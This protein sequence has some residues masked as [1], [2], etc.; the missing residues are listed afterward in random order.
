L[1]FLFNTGARVS[2]AV[3]LQACDLRLAPPA[4]VLL[5]GKG[6]KERVCPL[7]PET[8]RALREYLEAQEIG[9]GETRTVFHNHRGYP[10]TRFGVRWILQKHVRQAAR[11]VPSLKSKRLHPH[12]LRHGTAIHLLRSGVDLSMIA[13]WLGHA[14]VNTTYKYL[15]LNL[16]AKQEALAKAKPIVGHNGK[17]GRWRTDRNLIKWLE[18]L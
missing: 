15:S 2:E 3:G 13:H 18:S 12:S 7:W 4:S 14:S 16:E 17:P 5:K 1:S 10:L 11:H 6:S 8:A 9:L